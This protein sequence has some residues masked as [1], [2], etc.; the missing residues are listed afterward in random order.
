MD[1]LASTRIRPH[2][3]TVS[4]VYEKAGVRE[5]EDMR[6]YDESAKGVS[7]HVVQCRGFGFDV[8]GST[9]FG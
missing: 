9:A 4:F 1:G 7:P 2:L 6:M 8:R 5:A 3:A